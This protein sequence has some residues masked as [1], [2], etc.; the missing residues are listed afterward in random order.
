MLPLQL[1][2]LVFSSSAVAAQQCLSLADS[3]A[4]PEFKGYYVSVGDPSF[5]AFPWLVNVTTVQAFDEGLRVYNTQTR[6]WLSLGC[7][8]T[9]PP[10]YSLTMTCSQ[11]VSGSTT[12]LPCNLEYNVLPRPVCGWTCHAYSESIKSM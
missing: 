6:L 8:S 2:F 1:W 11:A 10:R 7:S 12:S 3:T 5:V 9:L 4:C